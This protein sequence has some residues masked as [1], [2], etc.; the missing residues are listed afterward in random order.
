MNSLS[1]QFKEKFADAVFIDSNGQD[2]FYV[3]NDDYLD[4]VQYLKTDCDITM[5]LDITAV[6]FLGCN[7][8]KIIDGIE[9]ERFEV[10]SNFISHKR[11]ERIRFIVQLEEN[12]PSIPS[13]SL[14]FPGANFG[15]RE[16]FDMFGINFDGHPDLTRI[17]MPEEWE[18]HPLRKDDSP[19]RIP[20]NFTDDIPALREDV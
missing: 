20:V 11:N 6:D 9:L 7:D 5:C 15:E 3:S 17:L 10:V 1:T 18:G 8:R 2:V 13:I 16:V 12:H 4:A 14:I 19:A